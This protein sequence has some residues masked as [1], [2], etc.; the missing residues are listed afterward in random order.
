MER[1]EHIYQTYLKIL[2][3]ELISAM[4]CTEPVSLAYCAAVARAPWVLCRTGSP[5]RPAG[6]SSKT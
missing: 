2:R 1:S 4:G 6:I 5:W 3:R